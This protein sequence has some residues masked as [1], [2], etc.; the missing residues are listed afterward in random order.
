ME[1]ADAVLETAAGTGVVARVLAP[2]LGADARYVV[3]DLNAPMLAIAD[4]KQP[5]DKRITW[6]QADALH[7][8][9]DD[10]TFDVVCCQFGAFRSVTTYLASAPSSGART[11]ATTPVPA[12]VSRTASAPS[13]IARRAIS[14]A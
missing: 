5:P 9:F 13:M 7:L 3:T 14:A 10:G 8:P 12:A 4:G 6:Q 1:G 2:L 11:R